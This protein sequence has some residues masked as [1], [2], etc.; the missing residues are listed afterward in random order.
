[1]NWCYCQL[2]GKVSM[3]WMLY[4]CSNTSDV[5]MHEQYLKHCKITVKIIIARWKFEQC[6]A[7]MYIEI[8]CNVNIVDTGTYVHLVICARGKLPDVVVFPQCTEH[9]SACA[10]LCYNS[11]V[12]IIPF[13]TG[14]GL[15]GGVT[16]IT[17]GYLLPLDAMLAW[18]M[19]SSY[20][21]PFV[22]HASELY[23]DG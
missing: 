10:Q 3:T 4:H 8:W 21:H 22:C 7:L 11:N 16:P 23:K 6:R 1:M 2:I 5:L 13:G 19:L 18:Y 15:E 20:V 14:T 12:P 17:V 9:V